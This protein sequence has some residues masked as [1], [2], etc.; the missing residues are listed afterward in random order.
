MPALAQ[1][2]LGQ[3]EGDARRLLVS[4]L[5][6]QPRV[7]GEV[8]EHAAFDL[9]RFS[10]MHPRVLERGLDMIDIASALQSDA[11]SESDS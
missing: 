8:R 5:F 11:T 3:L 6:G 7:T 1:S 9:P 2:G 4:G 10:P